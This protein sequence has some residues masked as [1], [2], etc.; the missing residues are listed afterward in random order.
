MLLP[1][2]IPLC[3]TI[4]LELKVILLPQFT[5]CYDYRCE[6]P[7]QAY[8][9]FDRWQ[10]VMLRKLRKLETTGC[11]LGVALDFSQA[12]LPSAHQSLLFPPYCDNCQEELW[13][14][15]CHPADILLPSGALLVLLEWVYDV[16]LLPS[17]LYHPAIEYLHLPFYTGHDS[18]T[19]FYCCCCC[20]ILSERRRKRG[21]PDIVV[22][23]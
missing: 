11:C 8:C 23:L 9:E 5:D 7:Y 3:R 4:N 12:V 2:E 10:K 14:K 20:W 17:L 16:A 1:E 22:Q 6:S 18:R 15:E 21:P 19:G 13:M